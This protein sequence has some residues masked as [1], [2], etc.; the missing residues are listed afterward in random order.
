M[1][2]RSDRLAHAYI[3]AGQAGSGKRQVALNLAAAVNCRE[4]TTG[5]ICGQCAAC[6][7]IAADAYPDVL[8]LAPDGAYVKREQIIAAQRW[9][10]L[11]PLTGKYRVLI[12]DRADTLTAE[13][14]NAALK[15]LEEPPHFA[16]V[17]LIANNS[18]SLL[19]TIRSRC[20]LVMFPPLA[21]EVVV[22]LLRQRGLDPAQSCLLAAL[23]GGSLEQALNLAARCDLSQRTSASSSLLDGLVDL[24]DAECLARAETIEGGRA[25]AVEMLDLTL[26]HLRDAL[27][28]LL[29]VSNAG[30]ISG[31]QGPAYLEVLGVD[32]LLQLI[33]VCLEVRRVLER[34]GNT[35]LCLDV[36][37]LRLRTVCAQ[38]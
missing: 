37:V 6:E 16:L 33:E 19:P 34:N 20:Q 25:D 17:I 36:L 11:R 29:G 28:R 9:I 13:A 27:L 3:F 5:G 35:R 32:R 21:E 10:A 14:S 2:V 26:L 7:Q 4:S 22:E 18:A 24:S 15:M 30:P 23:S 31:S 1:T 38:P 8:V 12:I